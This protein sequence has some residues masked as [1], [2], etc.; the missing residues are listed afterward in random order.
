MSYLSL[1]CLHQKVTVKYGDSIAPK[2]SFSWSLI[3]SVLC[4]LEYNKWPDTQYRSPWAKWP[5]VKTGYYQARSMSLENH[6]V[7]FR[8]T[9]ITSHMNMFSSCCMIYGSFIPVQWAHT[10]LF[11]NTLWL[12]DEPEG[13]QARLIRAMRWQAEVSRLRP[14]HHGHVCTEAAWSGPESPNI[15]TVRWKDPLAMGRGAMQSYLLLVIE[16]C[17]RLI[18]SLSG[19]SRKHQESWNHLRKCRPTRQDVECAKRSSPREACSI[20]PCL[21]HLWS[22]LMMRELLEHGPTAR[23]VCQTKLRAWRST[24]D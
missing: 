17:H 8:R 15:S 1:N 6:R 2:Q 9:R 20:R 21:K 4:P 11:P 24:D 12:S 13:S 18:S 14:N 22:R 5:P 23:S 10:D 19:V 3:V 7:K 16:R